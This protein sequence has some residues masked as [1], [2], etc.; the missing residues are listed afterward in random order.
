M[1]GNVSLSA[2]TTKIWESCCGCW[3]SS[4]LCCQRAL[5]F[6]ELDGGHWRHHFP[7]PVPKF[8]G[9]VLA[10]CQ[11]NNKI[12]QDTS[13]SWGCQGLSKS[14]GGFSDHWYPFSSWSPPQEASWNIQNAFVLLHHHPSLLGKQQVFTPN[15]TQVGFKNKSFN[16]KLSLEH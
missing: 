8:T 11:I 5:R 2:E 3:S 16:P 12:C 9:G 1:P 6:A 13:T 4:C 15:Y 14:Q 7:F 10:A